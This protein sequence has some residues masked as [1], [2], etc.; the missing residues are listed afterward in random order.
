MISFGMTE[1]QELVRDTLREFAADMLRPIGRECDENSEIPEDFLQS[2]WDLGLTSTQIPEEFGGAGEERSPVT[3]AILLE[4]LAHGDAALAI[5]AVAPSQ[6]ANAIVD[7]GSEAQKKQYLKLFCGDNYHAASLAIVEPGPLSD[8]FSPKTTAEPKGD[9]F[10]ISGQKSFVVM[11]DRA[12]HFLVVAMNGDSLEAFIVAAD[13]EG[14]KVSE[15]EQN[16][17]LRALPTVT[18]DFERVEVGA[19]D[20]LG[21][22]N[23]ADVAAIIG[24]SRAALCIVQ[25]G[26][27]RAVLEFC[28]PYTKERVAFDEPIA[29]KQSIAFRL[30]EMHIGV[31]S[32][33]YLTWQAASLLEHGEPAVREAR[34]AKSYV[35]KHASWIADNGIQVFGGHGYIREYPVEMWF[36]HAKTL[37]VLEGALGL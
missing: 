36:R 37:S 9:G 7:H 8:P 34:L 25:V 27:S 20:R 16:M 11:G 32:M 12:S 30:S 31:E 17:G 6:F 21:G 2:V 3:N 1:D 14:V 5:A 28:V 35:A 29:K 26:V 4:E 10:V 22:D 23:G 19:E 13:A 33:R 18:V 15:R 24:N